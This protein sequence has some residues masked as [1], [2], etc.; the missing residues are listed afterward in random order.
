[1][2]SRYEAYNNRPIKPMNQEVL[3]GFLKPNFDYS[4]PQH[5]GNE[6]AVMAKKKTPPTAQ[7]HDYDTSQ[8]V[9]QIEEILSPSKENFPSVPSEDVTKIRDVAERKARKG[10]ASS[11]SS[12][13]TGADRKSAKISQ[14]SHKGSER[15]ECKS[16]IPVSRGGV[17]TRTQSDYIPGKYAAA[18]KTSEQ[19]QGEKHRTKSERT[20]KLNIPDKTDTKYHT[21]ERTDKIQERMEKLNLSDKFDNR[22]EGQS[23]VRDSGV[24]SRPVSDAV[25]GDNGKV[26][27]SYK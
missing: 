6:P 10:S 12:I 15:S 16:N 11:S 7:A 24:Y 8:E 23:S 5:S 1:M 20:E 21:L 13:K 14:P 26:I 3:K 4:P 2:E 19:Q 9:S 25:L 17:V 27:D 22:K 18:R